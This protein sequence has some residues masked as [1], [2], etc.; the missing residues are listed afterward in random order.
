MAAQQQINTFIGGMDLDNDLS[1][2]EKNKY[3]YAQNVRIFTD[4]EGTTGAVQCSDF[5]N[6]C[7]TFFTNREI[8]GVAQC[9]YWYNNSLVDGIVVITL[10][11][12]SGE[13]YNYV[14]VFIEENSK[15]K[16]LTIVSGNIGLSKPVKIITNY[17]SAYVNKIYIVDGE[18]SMKVINIAEQGQYSTDPTKYDLVTGTSLF[19]PTFTTYTSGNIKTSVVQYCY[20]LY[21]S[22]VDMSGFSP[23]SERITIIKDFDN[24]KSVNGQDLDQTSNKGCQLSLRFLNVYGYDKIK[25][26]R[27]QYMN[28]T[29][30]PTIYEIIDSTIDTSNIDTTVEVTDSGTE[31]GPTIELEYFNSEIAKEN[32][33]STLEKKDNRLF[34]ANI[35]DGFWDVEYDARSFRLQNGKTRLYSYT[36]EGYEE[37]DKADIISK[38]WVVPKEHDCINDLN[39][40]IK[41]N[42]TDD[43]YGTNILGGVGPNIDFKII[44]YDYLIEE[45]D[46]NQFRLNIDVS[47][48]NYTSSKKYRYATKGVDGEYSTLTPKTINTGNL[49]HNYSSR[50]VVNNFLSYQRDEVYRFGIVFYDSKNRATPVK[51]IADIRFPDQSDDKTQAFVYKDDQL[52]SRPIGVEFTIKNFPQ[53]AVAYEIVRCERTSADRTVVCQVALS[54]TIKFEDWGNKNTDWYNGEFDRR[55]SVIPYFNKNIEIHKAQVSVGGIDNPFKINRKDDHTPSKTANDLFYMIS[56]EICINKDSLQFDDQMFILPFATFCTNDSETDDTWEEGNGRI[57]K[58]ASIIDTSNEELCTNNSQLKS[59]FGCTT[60]ISFFDVEDDT[61][62]IHGGAVRYY[63]CGGFQEIKS[64]KNIPYNIDVAKLTNS[65]NFNLTSEQKEIVKDNILVVDKYLFLNWAMG[66]YGV[67][68]PHGVAQVL[69]SDSLTESLNNSSRYDYIAGD[70]PYVLMANIKRKVSQYGGDSYNQRLNSVY[71]SIGYYSRIENNRIAVFG[72]DTYLGVFDY[73]QTGLFVLPDPLKDQNKKCYV[74]CYIPFESSINMYYRTDQHFSQTADG[75]TANVAY[76]TDGG[77]VGSYN[78]PT[79]MYVYN[80]VYSEFGSAKNMISD[81]EANSNKNKYFLNRIM[82]SQPKISNEEDDSW[83]DFKEANYLDVD[84]QYGQITNLKTFNGNLYFFQENAVG[85]A[86]VN[87]RSLVYDNTN[88]ALALGSGGVLTR[89]DYITTQ[90]GSQTI[91]DLSICSTDKGIYWYD[92]QNKTICGINSNG[93]EEL[94]K[95]KNVQSFI[96]K[97]SDDVQ[98]SSFFFRKNNEILFIFD[99]DILVF[100]ERLGVFT[101]FYD[102]GSK[103]MFNVGNNAYYIYGSDING[104]TND[105]Q[106]TTTSKL[107]IVVNDNFINTKVFDNQMLIGDIENDC[108]DDNFLSAEGSF[109][110]LSESNQAISTEVNTADQQQMYCYTKTQTSSPVSLTT[111]QNREDSYIFPIPRQT[112][113]DGFQSRMRGKYLVCN[114]Q[115]SSDTDNKFKITNI[116]TTYRYSLV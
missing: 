16:Q 33:I 94:S 2:I 72:G 24:Y 88:E 67:G 39:R 29:D 105:S 81:A 97:L 58:A 55:P 37:F 80:S 73:Q 48:S 71:K 44:T 78:Q 59:V 108:L 49:P 11:K 111:V 5:I 116:I 18:N 101:S 45:T 42:D 50:D 43:R 77:L 9:K 95:T 79:A 86:S 51:W 31:N 8:L 30:L 92:R 54:R 82:A 114:Y 46:I 64:D 22:D 100:N 84:N 25:V 28:N 34:S 20:R 83:K 87:E 23:I 15:F 60:G 40:Q 68:G 113:N 32:I 56:P 110:I 93:I 104:I 70:K 66:S 109:E 6:K 35:K 61:N 99:N 36:Q 47:G 1:I 98:V 14:Q 96:N 17:E 89:A 62:S 7:G 3:R 106:N 4:E 115:F 103:Y 112:A 90:F 27:V 52:Y 91:N 26:Y 41:Y 85:I 76:C 65:I 69:K 107:S 10:S 102:Y 13:V 75:R 74:Q 21:K 53:N 57:R 38:E 63:R 19:K 12:A